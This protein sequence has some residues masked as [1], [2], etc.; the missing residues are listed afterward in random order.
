MT[1]LTILNIVLVTDPKDLIQ[2]VNSESRVMLLYST[3]EEAIHILKA[4]QDYKITGE[5]YV[6]VVTQSVM[7]NLQTPFSFPVG[8][9]GE[10]LHILSTKVPV[11]VVEF[12][13][14][15]VYCSYF[16]FSLPVTFPQLFHTPLS[17]SASSAAAA[18][19]YLGPQ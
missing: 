13:L 16:G 9:L 15:Q 3:R 8:M 4:A 6:W 7:E 5:N 11:L 1:R 10:Y 12:S 18:V 19:M 14:V 2:L 17:T